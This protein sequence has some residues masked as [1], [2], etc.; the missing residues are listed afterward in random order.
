MP[1]FKEIMMT[2]LERIFFVCMLLV[3]VTFFSC[4]QGSYRGP[5]GSWG[6]MMGSGY[7]GGFMW[8]ILL[9]IVGVAIY[10]LLQTSK[11]KGTDAL[12]TETPLDI[13][14]KRYAMGDIDKE[15]FEQKKKDLE[16]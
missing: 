8:L 9:L 5:M 4:S 11:Q 3:P 12:V 6:H 1:L 7:G 2:V 10:F 15:E 13:L 14:K 16:S